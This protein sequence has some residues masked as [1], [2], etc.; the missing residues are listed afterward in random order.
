MQQRPNTCSTQSCQVRTLLRKCP[1]PAQSSSACVVPHCTAIP[2]WPMLS[3]EQPFGT[4]PFAVQS[5][6]LD[7]PGRGL[8]LHGMISARETSVAE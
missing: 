2:Q 3:P 4:C 1:V 6:T 5:E 7:S 8:Q